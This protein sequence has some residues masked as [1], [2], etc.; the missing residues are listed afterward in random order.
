ME[1]KKRILVMTAVNAEKDAVTRGIKN[2]YRYD[3]KLAGVGPAVAAANTATALTFENYDLVI[4][5]G[6]GGGFPNMAE[7]TSVA[8]ATEIISADLGAETS[9]GFLPIEEL[10]F[11]SSRVSVDI[12]L[13]ST[14]TKILSS[15]GLKVQSG[16]ILTLSTVTGTTET[17]ELLSKQYPGATAEAM[18]GFGVA[19]A[20]SIQGIPVLEIR[21]ISN[22]V[23]PRNREAWKLKE[24]LQSLE[25]TF[26]VLE[27]VL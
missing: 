2:N 25:T 1:P 5:A 9:E 27:E 26:S 6:I 21:T 14:I 16:P 18:E 10:G 23:G 13:V 22:A 3:V 11:G 20:A 15:Q 4:S 17:A 24:A 8:V 19:T 12:E 7:V